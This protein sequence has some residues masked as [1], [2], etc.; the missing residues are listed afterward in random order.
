MSDQIPP[1]KPKQ[2]P[3]RY[4]RKT[5]GEKRSDLVALR[6][7]LVEML[8]R[9]DKCLRLP[10]WTID[11]GNK[12]TSAANRQSYEATEALLKYRRPKVEIEDDNLIS[13][14]GPDNAS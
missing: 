6:A 7:V 1:V 3:K 11:Q 12:A 4:R 14:P 13:L 5:V 2:A 10:D 8:K 9:I